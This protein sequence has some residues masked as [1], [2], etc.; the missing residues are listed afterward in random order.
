MATS[1]A[2]VLRQGNVS[3]Q[4]ALVNILT[5]KT[6]RPI[7]RV[8][9]GGRGILSELDQPSLEGAIYNWLRGTRFFEKATISLAKDPDKFKLKEMR[10]VDF[11]VDQQHPI[12]ITHPDGKLHLARLMADILKKN[13]LVS[14]RAEKDGLYMAKDA[15]S[16]FAPTRKATAAD[17]SKAKEALAEG[18]EIGFKAGEQ[19]PNEDWEPYIEF[20]PT[21]RPQYGR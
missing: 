7:K 20:V 6:V 13:K 2:D 11:P 4:Q 8:I 3:N 15:E 17:V 9:P 18:E 10:V 5:K 12:W 14:L 19:I 16:V 1:K 21:R